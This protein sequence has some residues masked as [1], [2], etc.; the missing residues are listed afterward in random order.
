MVLLRPER[1]LVER[2]S[3]LEGTVGEELIRDSRKLSNRA[4]NVSGAKA[5][6]AQGVDGTPIGW[7]IIDKAHIC[8][9]SPVEFPLAEQ[10]LRLLQSGVAI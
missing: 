6:I 9:D 8:L 1:L 5:Q 3:L 10:L 4:F 2:G 7:P